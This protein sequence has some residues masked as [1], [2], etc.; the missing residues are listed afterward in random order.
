MALA[1]LQAHA[2]RTD[3][4]QLVVRVNALDTGLTDADLDGVVAGKP[5]MIL[6]PKAEGGPAVIHLDAKLTAREAIHGVTDGAIKILALATEA[7]QQFISSRKW[8]S[9]WLWALA[10]LG[11]FAAYLFANYTTT[12]MHWHF[13]AFSTKTGISRLI[14]HGGLF[15]APST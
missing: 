14:G 1:F 5:D 8:R 11:G 2:P 3:R 7:I 10:P 6:L 15:M 13:S 9:Q 4:P 12:G